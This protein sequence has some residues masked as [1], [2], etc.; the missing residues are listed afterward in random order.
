M[1]DIAPT[2]ASILGVDFGPCDG[3]VLEDAFF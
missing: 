2:I 3:K 1:V